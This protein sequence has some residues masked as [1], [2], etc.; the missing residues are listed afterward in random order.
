MGA[1][2]AKLRDANAR[3][4]VLFHE[5]DAESKELIVGVEGDTA[6]AAAEDTLDAQRSHGWEPHRIFHIKFTKEATG[7]RKKPKKNKLKPAISHAVG[8][9]LVKLLVPD[10]R[11]FACYV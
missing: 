11:K 8:F 5:L 2:C 6:L 4:M 10:I 3:L 7:G 1:T 9:G